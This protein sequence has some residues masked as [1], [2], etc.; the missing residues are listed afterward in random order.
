MAHFITCSLESFKY[1]REETVVNKPVNLDLC[2][3]IEKSQFAW[4]PDNAGKPSI[5]FNGCDVEWAYHEE[6]DRD[7]EFDRI[8]NNSTDRAKGT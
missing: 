3:S 2:T 4:Y 7:L 5:V 6:A 1:W 8:S